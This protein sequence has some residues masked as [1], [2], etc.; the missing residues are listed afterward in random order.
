MYSLLPGTQIVSGITRPKLDPSLC[1][2]Q[3]TSE[4]PP[5]SFP[6]GVSVRVP[7]MVKCSGEGE[8]SHR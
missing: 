5:S 3:C 7:R 6:H 8:I 4:I 1:L 2:T